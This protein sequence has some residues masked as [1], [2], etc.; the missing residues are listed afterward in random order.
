MFKK[1]F[2]SDFIYAIMKLK[3]ISKNVYEIA[4]EGEMKVPA[5]IYASE[6]LIAMLKSVT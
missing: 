6:E 4:R 1:L 2:K 5:R 3:K